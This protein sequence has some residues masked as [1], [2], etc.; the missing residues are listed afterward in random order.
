LLVLLVLLGGTALGYAVFGGGDDPAIDPTQNSSTATPQT[1][2]PNTSGTAGPAA[3]ASLPGF[4]FDV[5]TNGKFSRPCDALATALPAGAGL[6]AR[7]A[8]E[9]ECWLSITGARAATQSCTAPHTWETYVVGTLSSSANR[10]TAAR[11][12]QDA[13]AITMCSESIFDALKDLS[14]IPDGT[15]RIEVIGP[16][17]AGVDGDEFR[18]VASLGQKARSQPDFG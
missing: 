12:R 8:S 13:N 9:P 11:V 18:C 10:V 7:C 6:A 3:S 15:W 5:P 14:T 4:P 1:A 17:A 16:K 2:A